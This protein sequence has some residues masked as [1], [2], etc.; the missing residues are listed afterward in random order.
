MVVPVLKR[1]RAP[2]TKTLASERESIPRVTIR[3]P[4]APPPPATGSVTTLTLPASSANP[5]PTSAVLPPPSQSQLSSLLSEVR[6]E[7]SDTISPV[8]DL[9]GIVRHV[10]EAHF[11]P[12]LSKIPDPLVATVRSETHCRVLYSTLLMRLPVN[13]PLSFALVINELACVCA[14]LSPL[15]LN[16]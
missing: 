12:K 11:A 5:Q 1:K 3:L 15:V 9:E 16:A 7:L 10:Y 8:F 4:R 2:R 13:V 6:I 14:T